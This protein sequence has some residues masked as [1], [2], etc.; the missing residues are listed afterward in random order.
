MALDASKMAGKVVAHY[1]LPNLKSVVQV[2]FRGTLQMVAAY[3]GT[4]S[5]FGLQLIGVQFK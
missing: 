1:G 2:L 3:D 4:N 5:W